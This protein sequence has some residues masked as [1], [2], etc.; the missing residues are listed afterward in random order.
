ME[1]GRNGVQS[2]WLLVAGY[3][4]WMVWACAGEWSNNQDYN[5]GWFVAPLALYFWWKR[6]ERPQAAVTSDEWRV[7]S[8]RL[9]GEETKR[10]KDQET[11]RWFAWLV[12]LLSLLLIWPLE[13]VRQTPI[14]WRPI[15]WTIGLIAFGNSLA[16]AWLAGGRAALRRVAF[17]AAFMLLAIPWPTFLESAISFP[18]MQLVTQWSVGILHLLGYP[19]TAAGTTITLPNCTVGVEEACSGLRSLQTALMVGAAAGELARLKTGAR[20]ALLLVAFV[21]ALAGNQVRVL[22]LVMAGINGGNAAVSQ[23]H[24]TAGY[25][26]LAIL[27]GGVGIA[28]WAMGKVGLREYESGEVKRWEGQ[29]GVS[30]QLAEGREQN[31]E[32]KGKRVETRTEGAKAGWVVLGIAVASIVGA[33]AWFWWRG[34]L[35]PAQVAAMLSPAQSGDFQADENVP[36]EILG[37]LGPDEYRYIRGVRDG[38][39][40]KVAGYH[41]YWRPRKGNANQLYHR[42][43][44]CMPGAGWRIEG[45]VERQSVRLGDRE[46]VFNVFPFRG[47]GGP[48]LMLWGSFL[49]GEPVEIEFNSDVYVNTANLAQFIRTGTRTYSYEVAA[50]IMPYEGAR[51]SPEQIEAF[52]NRVFTTSVP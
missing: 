28:A 13:V 34:S 1:I 18:L 38:V 8:G 29:K 12:V 10:P 37:I 23:V 15:L 4:I 39:P 36:A 24:D 9:G 20:L 19:A 41:F 42:P 31:E 35:A 22:M 21:M 47:P 2:L 51:P 45:E 6:G 25:V 3:W 30:S 5:Y 27:L 17:P 33:H 50:L 49:N 32:C 52:A 43:D 26:V 40:G 14:H 44:R 48:A 46:F 11:G 7:A 16:V